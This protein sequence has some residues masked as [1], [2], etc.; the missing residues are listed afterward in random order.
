MPRREPLME[1]AAQHDAVH[2]VQGHRLVVVNLHAM[3]FVTRGAC[4]GACRIP[5]LPGL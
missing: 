2:F 5:L 3:N 4:S 1:L